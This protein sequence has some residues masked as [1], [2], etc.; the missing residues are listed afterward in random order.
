MLR[1]SANFIAKRL[2]GYTAEDIYEIWSDMGL[3][4][5]DKS[6]EWIL[7]ELGSSVGGRMSKNTYLAVPTFDPETIIAKMIEWNKSKKM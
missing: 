3:V 4:I 7:T 2:I 6:G 1:E 5:K